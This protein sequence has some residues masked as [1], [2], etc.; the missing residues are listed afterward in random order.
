VDEVNR[1]AE[2]FWATKGKSTK[3]AA[4]PYKPSLELVYPVL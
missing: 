3:K 4:A 2:I 1:F